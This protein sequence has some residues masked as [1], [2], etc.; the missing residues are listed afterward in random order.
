M[1]V[2][3]IQIEFLYVWNVENECFL[4]T[5]AVISMSAL[6]TEW[7]CCLRTLYPHNGLVFIQA[8]G[9]TGEGGGRVARSGLLFS[10]TALQPD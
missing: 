7:G 9:N 5:P 4:I 10:V 1:Q 3:L 2:T 6:I 8:M